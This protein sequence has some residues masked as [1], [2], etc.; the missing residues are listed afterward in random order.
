MNI[1]IWVQEGSFA[2]LSNSGSILRIKK[3]CAELS[4]MYKF[5]FDFVTESRAQLKVYWANN[6]QFRQRLGGYTALGVAWRNGPI[7]LNNERVFNTSEKRRIVE[8]LFQHE[9]GHTRG[10]DHTPDS[11]TD[12]V[13]HWAS[14]PPF[15]PAREAK[16][17][18]KRFRWSGQ[19]FYVVSKQI[20]SAELNRLL[21][22][23]NPLVAQRLELISQRGLLMSEYPVDWKQVLEIQADINKINITIRE[24]SETISDAHRE[25]WRLHREWTFDPKV[26]GAV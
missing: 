22:V 21:S 10:L 7:W 17:W 26:D 14:L 23:F 9:F 20:A 24:L 5:T 15:F 8:T 19:N 2:N 25:W 3:S 6:A 4:R 18:Q 1:R 13:M 12:T 16:N 11:E